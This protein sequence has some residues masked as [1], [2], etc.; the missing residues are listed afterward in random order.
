MG[1]PQIW[2]MT[3]T[4]VVDALRQGHLHPTEVMESAILRIESIDGEINALPI[5][6]FERALDLAVTT[7]SAAPDDTPEQGREKARAL[8]VRCVADMRVVKLSGFVHELLELL[9]LLDLLHMFGGKNR[10]AVKTE[11]PESNQRTET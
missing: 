3:A 5:R 2:Q 10:K 8:G 7:S 6:C 1:N 9:Q 4:A 11:K